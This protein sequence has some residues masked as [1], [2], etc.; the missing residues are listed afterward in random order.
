MRVRPHPPTEF[1]D[2]GNVD[3]PNSWKRKSDTV[4]PTMIFLFCHQDNHFL[5][6]Q[7][8]AKQVISNIVQFQMLDLTYIISQPV[9]LPK[10]WV[11]EEPNTSAK[12]E[13]QMVED[14]SQDHDISS[15][16]SDSSQHSGSPP[17]SPVGKHGDKRKVS[18]IELD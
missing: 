3:S 18:S 13:V 12:E 10:D 7:L 16:D 8:R 14:E 6:I 9:P 15:S 11:I 1:N 17:T 2:H 4:S 5:T